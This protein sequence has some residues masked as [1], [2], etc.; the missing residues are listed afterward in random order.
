MYMLSPFQAIMPQVS[1]RQRAI[2]AL[3]SIFQI[4]HALDS[5]R[6]YI[7]K[8][9][10]VAQAEMDELPEK[11]RWRLEKET[12]IDPVQLAAA[13]KEIISCLEGHID[14][15]PMWR[16]YLFSGR[17]LAEFHSGYYDAAYACLVQAKA[18]IDNSVASKDREWE[19]RLR[20]DGRCPQ[21][22]TYQYLWLRSRMVDLL[23]TSQNWTAAEEQLLALLKAAHDKPRT[24]FYAILGVAAEGD[25]N[26][27]WWGGRFETTQ[28]D[29]PLL[30]LHKKLA[31][32]YTQLGKPE[33]AAKFQAS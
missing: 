16:S 18:C 2:Y 26:D 22:S 17:A 9:R 11:Y 28:E 21:D 1:H 12:V 30:L 13:L 24:V 19:G 29:S 7:W 6:A 33:E 23:E 5:R 8:P 14:G 25:G 31:R 15:G 27:T 10:L 32:V 20:Y 3:Y 4:C